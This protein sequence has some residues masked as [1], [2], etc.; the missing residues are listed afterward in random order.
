MLKKL[1][2]A[3]NVQAKDG[4]AVLRHEL[5]LEFSKRQDHLK[6]C[7]EWEIVSYKKQF[8][9]LRIQ[10]VQR[11]ALVQ[12]TAKCLILQERELTQAKRRIRELE[13]EVGGMSPR[14]KFQSREWEDW[15]AGEPKEEPKSPKSK[16]R[17]SPKP[18][19]VLNIMK[20]AVAVEERK[21]GGENGENVEN[22]DNG[23]D[24]S[25]GKREES[26]IIEMEIR[27]LRSEREGLRMDVERGRQ[28]IEGLKEEMERRE[29]E[30]GSLKRELAQYKDES[31]SLQNVRKHKYE[32]EIEYLKAKSVTLERDFLSSKKNTVQELSVREILQKRQ[33]NYID[34][35]KKE[36]VLAKNIIKHPRLF[37]AVHKKVSECT[38]KSPFKETFEDG[39]GVFQRTSNTVGGNS[40]MHSMNQSMH[41]SRGCSRP[42]TQ[43][44]FRRFFIGGRNKPS[45]HAVLGGTPR[46][47]RY[48][49]LNLTS[50]QITT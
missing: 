2:I 49:T 9:D 23:E 15:E 22:V 8:S 47:L 28:E 25:S 18:R 12:N 29:G 38:S 43:Q 32:E 11:E 5:Q 16:K 50:P 44:V 20:E 17:K 36:L 13:D 26:E 39:I 45:T 37:S 42:N 6:K 31:N 40:M 34:T 3:K 10:F 27:E 48:N 21:N 19:G 41:A 14:R 46:H 33:S 7:F 30:R 1:N 4:Q 35:L 24:R